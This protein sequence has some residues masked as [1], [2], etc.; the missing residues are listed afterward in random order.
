MIPASRD[1]ERVVD[2]IDPPLMAGF[3]G[4]GDERVDNPR[5][6]ASRVSG[7]FMNA[8]STVAR[9]R[10]NEED[11]VAPGATPSFDR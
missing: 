1:T 5:H 4:W 7:G 10:A 11:G 8:V 9:I 2:K 6:R 3:D